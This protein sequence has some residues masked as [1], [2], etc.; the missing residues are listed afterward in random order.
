[1]ATGSAKQTQGFG[2]I[3][4]GRMFNTIDYS[5]P[6]SYVNGTGDTIDPR[7]FGFPNTIETFLQEGLD[8]TGTYYIFAQPTNT[9][10]TSWHIRWYLSAS[11][12]VP[13]GTNLSGV[14]VRL[15]AIGY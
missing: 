12:E 1:M 8:Q 2:D 3:F 15:S 5:G 10:V 14:T 11:T 9:G 4:G 7:I 13:N 6:T